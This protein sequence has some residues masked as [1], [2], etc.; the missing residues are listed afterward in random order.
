MHVF[1]YVAGGVRFRCGVCCSL[2]ACLGFFC[3]VHV[4]ACFVCVL[5]VLCVSRSVL[6][7][8]FGSCLSCLPSFSS[9]SLSLSLSFCL[10]LSLSASALGMGLLIQQRNL[11]IGSQTLKLW[12]VARFLVILYYESTLGSESQE[13]VRLDRDQLG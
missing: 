6:F 1:A 13:V 3:L 9:L 8:L 7:A 5:F 4:H 11:L 10:S 12:V 2:R